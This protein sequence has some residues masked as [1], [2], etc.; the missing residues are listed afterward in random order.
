MCPKKI[1]VCYMILCYVT[2]MYIRGGSNPTS[3]PSPFYKPFLLEKV[4]LSY[5]FHRKLH[6]FHIPTERLLRN[7]SLEKPVKYLEKSA[8]GCVFRDIDKVLFHSL[9]TVFPA[10]FYTSAGEIPTLS[11]TSSLKKVA[12]LGR[13]SLYSPLYGVPPPP[14]PP[15]GYH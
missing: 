10:L 5:T 1:K 13:A 14:P 11:Y 8:V 12:L 7:F 9:M 4:P 6:P 2:C 3:K 15:A